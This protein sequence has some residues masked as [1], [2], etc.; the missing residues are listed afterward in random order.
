VVVRQQV[1]LLQCTVGLFEYSGR[2]SVVKKVFKVI[3]DFCC[4]F[5]NAVIDALFHTPWPMEE[6][7]LTGTAILVLVIFETAHLLG[8]I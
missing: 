2:V 4:D 8:K 5:S 6:K 1:R 3:T 7:I